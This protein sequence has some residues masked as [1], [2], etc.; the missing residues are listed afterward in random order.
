MTG[1][2][3]C[4]CGNRPAYEALACAPCGNRAADRLAAIAELAPDARLVAA[5]LVRRGAGGSSGKP[6]SRPPLND[7]ATD[8]LTEVV[9]TLTTLARDIA[10]MRGIEI[11]GLARRRA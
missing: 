7:G 9:N 3:C 5:G 11:P 1:A 10:E 4:V 8:A 6:G 2:T